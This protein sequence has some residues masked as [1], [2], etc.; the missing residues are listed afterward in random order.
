MHGSVG[1]SPCL[2]VFGLADARSKSGP[3][4]RLGSAR[5]LRSMGPR[6]CVVPRRTGASIGTAG[7][8][9]ACRMR[10]ACGTRPVRLGPCAALCARDGARSLSGPP[11]GSA[12]ASSVHTAA[13]GRVGGLHRVDTAARRPRAL[14]TRPPGPILSPSA[15]RIR[16]S[17]GVRPSPRPAA[18]WGRRT[19]RALF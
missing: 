8:W 11:A 1:T 16:R 15:R 2:I 3:E 19:S 17:V 14:R 9:P 5:G 18:P 4:E 6:W 13:V 10:F 12:T 7:S